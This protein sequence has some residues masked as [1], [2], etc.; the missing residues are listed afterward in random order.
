MPRRP[1]PGTE[2]EYFLICFDKDGRERAEDGVFL[3]KQVTDLVR[4]RGQGITDVFVMS[5]GWMGDVPAAI[6]QYERWTGAMAA[7]EGDRKRVREKWQGFKALLIGFHWPSLPWG[8]EKL[9]DGSY[10]AEPVGGEEEF[11]ARWADR[12]ADSDAAA[13]A[14]RVLFRAAQEDVEPDVLSSEVVAA[15]KTLEREAGLGAEGVGGP[16]DADREPMDPQRV[17]E[18]W[19]DTDDALA[20]SGGL[21]GGL[22]SPLRPL[23]FW[24]MK[25]R[26]RL[27]GESGGNAL[28]RGLVEA[29]P[30]L[31]VHLMGHSFGCIVTSGMLR[32]ANAGGVTV[33]TA[34]LVQGAMSLWSYASELPGKPGASGYFRPIVERGAVRGATV[35]T[36]SRFD[37]AVGIL[38]PK[39]AGLL[40]QLDYGSGTLVRQ[41]PTYGA[42][43][44]FG[45]QGAGLDVS[46][47]L[48]A[49]D[50][51]HDYQFARG[52]VYNV[53]ADTVIKTGGGLSGAHSDIAHAE[54]GHAFW[55][56][57]L[58]TPD[59]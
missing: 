46:P 56:A 2:L 32:G 44:T 18:D 37:R 21:M 29:R 16:P 52:G 58:A 42:V 45:L 6:D 39:A 3:S 26:A 47:R 1:V 38:Y 35:V 19:Q 57:V 28:L 15:Y 50:L 43:G 40:R 49:A 59:A 4:D 30:D 14:L 9:S 54:V 5:H 27:V 55:E 53:N 7:C 31:R 22:L 34:F 25:K 13:E 11:V 17:Y 33:S 51:A 10:A 8:D 20:Y 36:T 12:I 23:S 41:L 48:I 24:T